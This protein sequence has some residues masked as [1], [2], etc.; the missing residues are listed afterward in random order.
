MTDIL[1]RKPSLTFLSPFSFLLFLP[2]ATTCL[3]SFLV[4]TFP[5]VLL[6]ESQFALRRP[7]CPVCSTRAICSLR[8]A[9][10]ARHTPSARCPLPCPLATR[11]SLAARYRVRSLHAVRS[12]RAILRSARCTRRHSFLLVPVLVSLAACTVRSPAIPCLIPIPRL[13]TGSPA[14][15]AHYSKGVGYSEWW[16]V[17]DYRE[18]RDMMDDHCNLQYLRIYFLSG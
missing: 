8:A 17:R 5:F 6:E 7:P 2:H 1:I 3:P 13:A 16:S 11:R 9:L 10:S 12:L 14:D 18:S 15:L 4:C